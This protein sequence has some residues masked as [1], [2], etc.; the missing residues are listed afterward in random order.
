[1]GK[2]YDLLHTFSGSNNSSRAQGALPAS[3]PHLPVREDASGIPHVSGLTQHITTDVHTILAVL[4]HGARYKRVDAT[5]LNAA[6][7][8]GHTLFQVQLEQRVTRAG[9]A[10]RVT[11]SYMCFVDLAGSERVSKTGATGQALAEAT[12]INSTLSTLGTVVSILS[13]ATAAE[14]ERVD[15]RNEGLHGR[16]SSTTVN[17][18]IPWRDSKLTRLLQ[19]AL[20][21]R[22]LSADVS[23]AGT[24]L[25]RS[26]QCSLSLLLAL[27]PIKQHAAE[28][29]ST[30]L[31]GAR[32][33]G[34]ASAEVQMVRLASP[35]KGV[36]LDSGRG[37]HRVS[38]PTTPGGS[39][40][41]TV[42]ATGASVSAGVGA[43]S[44]VVRQL[45]SQLDAQRDAHRTA[46]AAAAQ[47][48]DTITADL[49]AAIARAENAD[50]SLQTAQ[51]QIQELQQELQTLSEQL[52]DAKQS[53]ATS[54]APAPCS[55]RSQQ[56]RASSPHRHQPASPGRDDPET[57][58]ALKA[59][60]RKLEDTVTTLASLGLG[61]GDDAASETSRA[62]RRAESVDP[63]E[64]PSTP[65]RTR[66]SRKPHQSDVSHAYP[67]NGSVRTVFRS[68]QGWMFPAG[69]SPAPRPRQPPPPPHTEQQHSYA[70]PWQSHEYSGISAQQH[71]AAGHASSARHTS[72][73][74]SLDPA[75][76]AL[77][78]ALSEQVAQLRAAGKQ[79]QGGNIMP[80]M[81]VEP[82]RD[83]RWNPRTSPQ[84]GHQ[85]GHPDMD[86][87]TAASSALDSLQAIA[88]SNP[89]EWDA[90]SGMPVAELQGPP[91]PAAW[92]GV[93][94]HTPLP[95][96][97]AFST[98]QPQAVSAPA[99]AL[100]STSIAQA[101]NFRGPLPTAAPVSTR[102]PL[103]RAK[104]H[105]KQ[106]TPSPRV[107]S[108]GPGS[109]RQQAPSPA[110][111]DPFRRIGAPPA[112]APVKTAARG[113]AP[114]VA[115]EPRATPH[116][117]AAASKPPPR[118]KVSVAAV[119]V[120]QQPTTPPFS[121]PGDSL[122]TKQELSKAQPPVG[123]KMAPAPE[124]RPLRPSM[125]TSVGTSDDPP[126]HASMTT[127][128]KD[129][130]PSSPRRL[131][132]PTGHDLSPALHA[133]PGLSPPMHPLAPASPSRRTLDD[134]E[135]SSSSSSDSTLQAASHVYS[136]AVIAAAAAAAANPHSSQTSAGRRRASWHA[137]RRQTLSPT[138]GLTAGGARSPMQGALQRKR[139]GSLGGRGAVSPQRSA[140]GGAAEQ[141][142][143]VHHGATASDLAALGLSP[144]A[145]ALHLSPQAGLQLSPVETPVPA[146]GETAPGG[147][148]NT[149]SASSEHPSSP[150][151]EHMSN[152]V[153]GS[154][155]APAPQRAMRV[156]RHRVSLSVLQADR[157]KHGL[158]QLQPHG[159]GSPPQTA[160]GVAVLEA[161]ADEHPGGLLP[162]P[163]MSG[164]PSRAHSMQ[165]RGGAFSPPASISESSRGADSDETSLSS[166]D[167]RGGSLSKTQGGGIRR[168]VRQWNSPLKT[169]QATY[170]SSSEPDSA[171]R[172]R[173]VAVSDWKGGGAVIE[174][175]SDPLEA[176]GLEEVDLDF[177][178]A[179]TNKARAVNCNHSATGN[180]STCSQCTRHATEQAL[181]QNQLRTASRQPPPTAPR[182]PSM[183]PTEAQRRKSALSVGA[184]AGRAASEGGGGA[185]RCASVSTTGAALPLTLKQ[186]VR[187]PT[188]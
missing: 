51:Q 63:Y 16:A 36:V 142:L 158:Q 151:P 162:L 32:A 154:A 176:L 43:S 17:A 25:S 122:S 76:A 1:M 4:E 123:G 170:N 185:P 92:G 39:T 21:G 136:P 181:N 112:A 87:Y 159:K 157:L 110:P 116:A 23:T 106:L 61:G 120:P 26:A 11:A 80:T 44:A 113:A 8:R 74:V 7:S 52:L 102:P 71:G 135:S 179:T 30:L 175:P 72:R 156:Q 188:V 53:T 12:D 121:L 57:V 77:V 64:P 41:T 131:A 22:C 139:R 163:A 103:D 134:L 93:S 111:L 127:S 101:Q 38:A 9:Q 19:A 59:R 49:M 119:A 89:Y 144:A 40:I 85:G 138:L 141:L 118:P 18:H 84:R 83:P 29:I 173:S 130:M 5:A 161:V 10:P 88:N 177:G 62:S 186:V 124:Q 105:P 35:G 2:V 97:I 75:S 167:T 148:T 155:G 96:G 46:M 132:V 187:K 15:L 34:M 149:R 180:S 108:A 171:S 69:R 56:S 14:S 183:P 70:T 143:Q 168:S 86:S 55:S 66:S 73:Q 109:T 99:Y 65:P 82:P 45:Q 182:P 150:I 174:T 104:F 81:D 115:A 24:A 90:S 98:P 54:P 27:S 146:A 100:P 68:P 147:A 128:L 58:A 33:R 67:D 137:G 126:V 152:T 153:V 91:Q 164:P 60:L 166:P 160:A 184:S 50:D 172:K 94:G 178:Q 47:E 140:S 117:P 133:A 42:D 169:A 125:A 107:Q 37:S 28:S 165:S 145:Y 48:R 114:K 95:S 3:P 79:V 13:D 6:S 31:F 20:Y 129:S 78:S